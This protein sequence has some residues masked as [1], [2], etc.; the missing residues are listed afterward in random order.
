MLYSKYIEYG[1]LFQ[2][3][4]NKKKQQRTKMFI[5]KRVFSWIMVD[6]PDGILWSFLKKI[7]RDELTLSPEN[8]ADAERAII[9]KWEKARY[10]TMH[11]TAIYIEYSN[12]C[13]HINIYITQHTCVY[14]TVS[15]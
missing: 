1:C 12:N 9:S 4:F 3:C 7:T 8:L 6:A 11:R 5:K 10:N 13:I 2:H 15:L 14:C